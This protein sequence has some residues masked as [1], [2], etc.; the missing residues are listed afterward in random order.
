MNGDSIYHRV[1]ES[2]VDKYATVFSVLSLGAVKKIVEFGCAD[3]YFLRFMRSRGLDA[4]GVEGDCRAAEAARL[5]G[6]PVIQHDLELGLPK[7][8]NFDSV[9]AVLF[10][11]I[12]EHLR[13]PDILLRDIYDLLPTGA[14]VIVTGPNVAHISM[15]VSLFRGRF[16]YFETGI[17]DRTHL[18]FFTLATWST[19]LT[20]AGFSIL[21]AGSAEVPPLPANRLISSLFGKRNANRLAAFLSKRFPTLF[22]VVLVLV[23]E[24]R[25]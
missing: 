1:L 18:R 24:K 9:D 5:A 23:A 10:M 21:E 4:V 25:S 8:V 19:L 3:G 15:R 14:K 17:T 6:L 11:D 20:N 16:D 13:A 12:L 7:S 22:S 2:V